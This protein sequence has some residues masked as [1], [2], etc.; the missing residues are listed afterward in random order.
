MHPARWNV[1]SDGKRSDIIPQTPVADL[2]RFGKHKLAVECN[3][4]HFTLFVDDREVGSVQ[5]YTF[6]YGM[7]GIGVF[8]ECGGAHECKVI[9]RDL[10]VQAMP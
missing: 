10:L 2:D 3:R 4:G 8:G 5:D 7:V 6:G 1:A 9:A